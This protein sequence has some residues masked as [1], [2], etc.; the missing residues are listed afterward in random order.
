MATVGSISAVTLAV[1]VAAIAGS[2]AVRNFGIA[3]FNAY[4]NA[5]LAS[6]LITK[7][8]TSP[9]AYTLGE[10]FA[11]C[12]ARE[13]GG[14]GKAIRG[15]VFRC[16]V[17]GFCSHGPQLH[18]WSLILDRIFGTSMKSHIVLGKIALDQTFFALYLNG[19]YMVLIEVLKL[20]GL[21]AA[22][23]KVR[24]AAIPS[25]KAN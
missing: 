17:T 10:L 11:Q 6:P 7:S 13:R 4:E 18:Y 1:N 24:A 23:G 8:T 20:R 2:A 25:L 3:C 9:I 5:G 15:A 16:S 12:F 19:A 21:R 14:G 22:W